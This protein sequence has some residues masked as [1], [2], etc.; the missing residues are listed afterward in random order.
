[1]VEG[2]PKQLSNA[3]PDTQ[4]EDEGRENDA[5]EKLFL[6]LSEYSKSTKLPATRLMH[7]IPIPMKTEEEDVLNLLRINPIRE[8]DG[9]LEIVVFDLYQKN[10]GHT[11]QWLAFAAWKDGKANI[12][13]YDSP[14]QEDAMQFWPTEIIEFAGTAIQER[15]VMQ[16]LMTTNNGTIPLSNISSGRMN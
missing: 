11:Q 4:A 15:I 12:S 14:V 9:Q 3:S 10:M 16:T 2:S 6:L 1:M 5:F 7:T 13:V 8:T